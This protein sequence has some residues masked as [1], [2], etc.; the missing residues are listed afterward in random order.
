METKELRIGNWI[1]LCGYLHDIEIRFDGVEREMEL[2]WNGHKE[3]EMTFYVQEYQIH[4]IG[5]KRCYLLFNNDVNSKKEYS[6]TWEMNVALTKDEATELCKK[7]IPEYINHEKEGYEFRINRNSD[8]KQ[9]V[10]LMKEYLNNL[11]SIPQNIIF[12]PYTA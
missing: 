7:Y 4:S 12:N 2:S 8:N 11:L 6:C 5:K 1:Y 9:Y 10:E 3:K